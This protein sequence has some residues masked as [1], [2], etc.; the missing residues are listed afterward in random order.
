MGS[1]G[2]FSVMTISGPRVLSEGEIE[3]IWKNK[4][5]K[6]ASLRLRESEKKI[7]SML[8]GGVGLIQEE[9][10]EVLLLVRHVRCLPTQTFVI[11]D[12]NNDDSDAEFKREVLHIEKVEPCRGRETFLLLLSDGLLWRF[13]EEMPVHRLDKNGEVFLDDRRRWIWN[14]RQEAGGEYYLKYGQLLLDILWNYLKNGFP[15]PTKYNQ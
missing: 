8:S 6:D 9:I 10:N 5:L 12:S 3:D 2:S 14:T 1:D 15:Y 4:N 7:E 13:E 11:K